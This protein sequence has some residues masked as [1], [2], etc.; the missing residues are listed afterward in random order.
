MITA[1]RAASTGWSEN[2]PR[3]QMYGAGRSDGDVPETVA[4]CLDDLR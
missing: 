3:P 1:G 2:G 4:G